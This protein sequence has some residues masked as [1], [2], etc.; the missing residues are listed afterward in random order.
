MLTQSQQLTGKRIGVISIALIFVIVAA[1]C[2]ADS[3]PNVPA[4]PRSVPTATLPPAAGGPTAVAPAAPPQSAA[5][6]V[7][8]T[9]IP[10]AAYQMQASQFE[11]ALV[12]QGLDPNSPTGQ[13][14][15]AQMRAQILDS[16][17]DDVLI[18]QEAAKEGTAVSDADL[19]A[20]MQRLISDAGGQAAFDQSL[21][22]AGQTL[23]DARAV[24]RTQ[25]LNNLMRDRV[26]TN[27]PTTAEQV[28][29]RHILV[30]SQ[31]AADALLAQLKAGA[32]F[33]QMA[34][35]SSQDSLTRAN[36]GDMSWFPRGW[37]PSKE[38]EDAAFALQPGQISDVVQSAFGFHII[39]VIDRDPNR[40]LPPEK[41]LEL[42]K[43]AFEKWL[44]GLRAAAKVERLAGQ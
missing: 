14:Q 8:G 5:A 25:M 33:V 22:A 4:A 11:A 12:A 44:A 10:L 41:L 27:V 42:Q 3:G 13:A 24:Q 38:V 37:L 35:Q 21:V 6:V 28:H 15:I 31:A 39:Q 2:G 34:Q 30:D 18:A 7:N 23:D 40:A 29:A 43:Q 26:L 1:G 16:M 36:G 19:E 9:S 17:I 20:A 32:D